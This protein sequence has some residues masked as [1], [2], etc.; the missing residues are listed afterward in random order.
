M[1][2]FYEPEIFLLEYCLQKTIKGYPLAKIFED[3]RNEIIVW[4][5][6]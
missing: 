1:G 4:Y 6:I 2:Y 3:K 5:V